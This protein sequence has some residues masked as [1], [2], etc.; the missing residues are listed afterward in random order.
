MLM[1]EL[2]KTLYSNLELLPLEEYE[3][4]LKEEKDGYI[5]INKHPED[6]NIIILNYN[7]MATYARHW[8]KYTMSARGLILDITNI[9]DNGLIY[10]LGKPFDK[11]PNYGSNEIEGYEDD[12]DFEK[13]TSIMEKMDGS[14][15]I[16]YFFKDEI[17][18]ATRGSFASDQA[19]RA[20]EI[21]RNKYAE[22]FQMKSWVKYPFTLLVEIIYPENRVVVDYN[23]L[24][25]LVLLG[26]RYI[27]N[28]PDFD[29][30]TPRFIEIL[31]GLLDMPHAKQ[32]HDLTIDKML[33][34]REKISANEEGWI[35]TFSNK[36]RLKIKGA[37]Y[38]QVHKAIHGLS[39]KAKVE[40]WRD[41]KIDDLI[42]TMP[43]E[44]RGE[45]EKVKQKLDDIHNSI[46]YHAVIDY[47]ITYELVGHNKKEFAQYVVS[48]FAPPFRNLMFNAY[49]NGGQI[50]DKI[51]KEHIFKN[52]RQI[53]GVV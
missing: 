49:N 17:R 24:S 32:Y 7:E 50:S 10:I 19:I 51:I 42:L 39:P 28:K 22:H 18:F 40:A 33:K 21:W 48:K 13:I 27:E 43:E 45:I 37:E 23:G 12:I 26:G 8:N 1:S 36:K 15:G 14:L 3:N 31:A 4:Y 38:L 53:L 41:D 2:K 9:K 35:I 25:D 11:F 20:T 5:R 44:F 34:M 29:E 16:S 46:R 30:L 6:E 47:H 52:Y